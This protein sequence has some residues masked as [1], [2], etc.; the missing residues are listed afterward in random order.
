MPT[1][2]S[3]PPSTASPIVAHMLRKQSHGCEIHVVL[4]ASTSE[5]LWTRMVPS[6]G[7]LAPPISMSVSSSSAHVATGTSTARAA[8][9]VA[10]TAFGFGT[11]T[12]GFCCET[13]CG[14]EPGW[15]CLGVELELAFDFKGAEGCCFLPAGG[16]LPAGGN[17]AAGG[18]HNKVRES[19][20]FWTKAGPMISKRPR[21]EASGGALS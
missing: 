12:A 2:W 6:L 19:S 17:V 21:R 5:S 3:A 1:I 14:G 15:C 16:S 13:F 11:A 9:R 10:F 18:M 8:K 20:G 7:C 4:G